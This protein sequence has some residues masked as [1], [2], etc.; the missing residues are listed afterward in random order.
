MSDKQTTTIRDLLTPDEFTRMQARVQV[1]GALIEAVA[2]FK[3]TGRSR[4][5]AIFLVNDTW[6]PD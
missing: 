5:E 1:G 6:G 3:A 2:R 4:E